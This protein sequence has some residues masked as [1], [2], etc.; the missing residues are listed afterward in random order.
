MYL[1]ISILYRLILWAISPILLIFIL[2]HSLFH[3]I[4]F[5]PYLYKTGILTPK[6]PKTRSIIWIHGVSAGEVASMQGIAKLIRDEYDLLITSSTISGWI[7]AKKHF[8]SDTHSFFPLDYPMICKRLLKKVQP[9]AVLFIEGETW[10][11]FLKE[12]ARQTIPCCL[13]SGKLGDKEFK[14]YFRLKT[15]FRKVF[16]TFQIISMQSEEDCRKVHDLGVE[17]S[18]VFMG[19]NLKF[20][21]KIDK[22]H[23]N[24]QLMHWS[25][26]AHVLLAASTHSGEEKIIL[27][28]Y[29]TLYQSFPHLKIII[30]PRH[31]ERSDSIAK[32]ASKLCFNIIKWS[33]CRES[34]FHEPINNTDIL[35]L[36][37]MGELISFY[38]IAHIVLLAGS[39]IK[40]VGGH[41]PVEP[42]YFAKPIIIG[43]YTQNYD[44]MIHDMLFSSS[45]IQLENKDESLQNELIMTIEKLIGD[46]SLC[47]TLGDKAKDFVRRHQGSSL[48]TF[49][50][51][52]PYFSL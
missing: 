20:D 40:G 17:P 11:N 18:K 8:P 4:Q 45:I 15:F 12:A 39:F 10:P 43:P 41:N 19:G 29:K 52:K 25:K 21:L 51:I 38:S 16:N 13:L 36:D 30:A 9:K 23:I 49:N 7:M 32:M 33:D 5:I 27:K 42:A 35:I 1:F 50:K 37:T 48:K 34:E 26:N 24:H 3:P 46:L 6:V 22:A 44:W 47:L 2:I 31:P 14:G 28:A